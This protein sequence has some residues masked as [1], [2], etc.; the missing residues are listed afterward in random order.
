M[1]SRVSLHII[2]LPVLPKPRTWVDSRRPLHNSAK[3]MLIRRALLTVKRSICAHSA[4]KFWVLSRGKLL[5]FYRSIVQHYSAQMD[6]SEMYRD[7]QR[8]GDPTYAELIRAR[9]RTR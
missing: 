2:P 7:V 6:A 3:F 5:R 1:D 8:R 9:E 4:P